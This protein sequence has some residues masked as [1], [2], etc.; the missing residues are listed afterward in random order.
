MEAD[1]E[2]FVLRLRRAGRL[3]PILDPER[4]RRVLEVVGTHGL[5]PAPYFVAPEDGLLVARYLPGERWPDDALRE[6]E[7]LSRLAE[8]LRELHSLPLSGAGY[9]PADAARCYARAAGDPTAAAPV[10]ER[11]R[12]LPPAPAVLCH[13]DLVASNVIEN[14]GRLR[15]IDW[16]YA[17]DGDAAYELAVV[18][19]CHGLGD[20]QRR[21]LLESYGEIDRGRVDSM[22]EIYKLVEALW[23]DAVAER[24]RGL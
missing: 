11:L 8:R 12:Q 10:I 5:G 18:I 2:R 23:I 16:E 19:V 21:A 3:A 7:H 4:E 14:D 13:N 17:G 9:T 22:I 1:G 20:A 6:P 24:Q 15:F